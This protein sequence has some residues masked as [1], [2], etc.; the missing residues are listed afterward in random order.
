MEMTGLLALAPL[1]TVI[2]TAIAVVI[3]DMI[4]PGDDRL[5]GGVGVIGL[6]IAL[7]MVVGIGSDPDPVFGGAY[8]RDPLTAF[9]DALF[10]VVAA[11]TILFAPDYLR[12]RGLPLG[13]YTATLLF[14]ITGAMLIAGAQDLLI[15]FLGLELLVLPGYMLAGYA[16]RDGSRPRA[17]SSTSC[18]APSAPSSCSAWRSS[19]ASRA[20]RG[21]PRSPTRSP[22]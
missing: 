6:L 9:L 8:V 12:P 3:V 22:G 7:A 13:E 2:A 19:S 14:A 18:W 1:I 16:K 4:R 17:P 5:A 10:I 21:S 15:L 11:L 20:R